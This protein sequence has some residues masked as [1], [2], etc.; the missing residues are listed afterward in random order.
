MQ[1]SRRWRIRST[2]TVIS[3]GFY[4]KRFSPRGGSATDVVF[5][6][7]RAR[8]DRGCEPTTT[9]TTDCRCR[10]GDGRSTDGRATTCHPTRP[11][12]RGAS[13]SASP[14]NGRSQTLP[15]VTPTNIILLYYSSRR[16]CPAEYS[17]ERCRYGYTTILYSCVQVRYNNI[18]YKIITLI[19]F[20]ILCEYL[21]Q[22]FGAGI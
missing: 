14:T 11:P 3:I 6:S 5:R 18:Y 1:S 17:S 22:V 15:S 16:P 4:S 2:A 21:V 13:V 12:T 10:C 8:P 9:T 20:H 19:L 7:H